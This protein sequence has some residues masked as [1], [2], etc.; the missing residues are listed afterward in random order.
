MTL[1][2]SGKK[3]TIAYVPA[4][5]FPIGWPNLR[6]PYLAKVQRAI[7]TKLMPFFFENGGH[8]NHIC[9]YWLMAV[10][11]L[12]KVDSKPDTAGFFYTLKK[13]FL[14]VISCQGIISSTKS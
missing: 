1:I 5:L 4:I 8:E 2:F 9:A 10:C 14:S 6:T 12:K 13:N 7:F 3:Y 11:K